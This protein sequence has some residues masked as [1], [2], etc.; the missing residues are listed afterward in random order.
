MVRMAGVCARRAEPLLAPL[1]GA[2]QRRLRDESNCWT[3]GREGMKSYNGFDHSQRTAALR[4]IKKEWAEGR[5]ALPSKCCV[6]GQAKGI[7]D[8]HSEDYSRPFGA[9][10]GQFELCFRCHMMIHCRFRNP[11]AFATY[12]EALAKGIRFAPMYSRN[13]GAFC[14]DHLWHSTEPKTE[15]VSRKPLPGFAPLLALGEKVRLA[16]PNAQPALFD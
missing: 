8:A 3:G 15:K 13:F 14:N 12:C 9:H 11:K 10:I 1:P 5:R 4:W 6:C 7:I 16:D 2:N